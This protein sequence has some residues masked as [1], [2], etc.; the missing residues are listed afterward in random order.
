[1]GELKPG[2]QFWKPTHK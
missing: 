1:M 2:N